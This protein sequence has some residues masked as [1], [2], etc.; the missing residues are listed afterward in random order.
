MHQLVKFFRLQTINRKCTELLYTLTLNHRSSK[1]TY[2]QSIRMSSTMS[3][4]IKVDTIHYL[5]FNKRKNNDK[6][7]TK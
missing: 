5:E 7:Q 3:P 2:F 1:G 6:K 4:G